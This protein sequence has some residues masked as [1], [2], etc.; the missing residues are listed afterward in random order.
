MSSVRNH[1]HTVTVERRRTFRERVAVA[2]TLVFG[3]NLLALTLLVVGLI[4]GWIH[5]SF[6]RGEAQGQWRLQLTMNTGE[7][8]EDVQETVQETQELAGSVETAAEMNTVI[9]DVVQKDGAANRLTVQ[10]DEGEQVTARLNNAT[11]VEVDGAESSPASIRQGDRV[12]LV[13]R[14]NN[15]E[16]H[17]VKV[18]RRGNE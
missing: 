16:N 6:D 4:A 8:V 18:E 13:F 1:E 17:A 11:E 9:G 2:A 12:E 3:L 10:T 15:G 5:L 7:V 14:E